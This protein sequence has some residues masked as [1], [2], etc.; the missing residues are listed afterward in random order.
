[1]KAAG[2]VSVVPTKMERSTSANSRPVD[3]QPVNIGNYDHEPIPRLLSF[4]GPTRT[5]NRIPLRRDRY[6][7]DHSALPTERSNK[8]RYGGNG[9]AGN[10]E[11]AELKRQS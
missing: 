2:H 6:G 11:Q 10:G 3:P 4:N 8:G 9:E 5:R 7:I 1:M